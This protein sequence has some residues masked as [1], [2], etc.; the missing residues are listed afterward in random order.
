MEQGLLRAQPQLF[1]ARCVGPRP[2]RQGF[3][4]LLLPAL[5][6]GLRHGQP[7]RTLCRSRCSFLVR[8]GQARGRDKLTPAPAGERSP[9]LPGVDAPRSGLRCR[10]AP[11]HQSISLNVGTRGNV[12]DGDGIHT[13]GKEQ[14]QAAVCR[15]PAESRSTKK[16]EYK[17]MGTAPE[18]RPHPGPVFSHKGSGPFGLRPLGSMMLRVPHRHPA[19]PGLPPAA[20]QCGPRKRP[21]ARC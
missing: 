2:G 1:P 17:K 19:G 3:G 16:S 9:I 18:R 15:Q 12:G 7:W 21:R 8:K 6:R 10:P 4:S 11:L 13:G 14:A 5:V 20:L